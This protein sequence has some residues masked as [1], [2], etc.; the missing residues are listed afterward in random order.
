MAN[1]NRDR[2]D[3]YERGSEYRDF[4]R[5]H[6]D[7]GGSREYRRGEQGREYGGEE[8]HPDYSHQPTEYAR[9]RAESERGGLTQQYNYPGGSYATQRGGAGSQGYV[10]REQIARYGNHFQPGGQTPYYGQESGGGERFGEG[11]RSAE[12]GYSGGSGY[13]QGERSGG[14]QSYEANQGY[15]PAVGVGQGYSGPAGYGSQRSGEGNDNYGGIE[16]YRGQG[17]GQQY[18]LAGRAEGQYLGRSGY[19]EEHPPGMAP[20]GAGLRR[21]GYRGRGPRN[22]RRSDERITEEINDR[23]T[24]HDELDAEEIEVNV[25]GGEVILTGTV[26]SRESKRLAEDLAESVAGVMQVQN[27]LRVSRRDDRE[28]H[29]EGR[30]KSSQSESQRSSRGSKA[31]TS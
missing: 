21:G 31:S 13:S 5:Q 12:R 18:G 10:E 6:E 22:Y 1:Y 24:D 14:N 2:G 30:G 28:R 7:Q 19:A 15:G 29:S 4:G 9:R 20:R 23:L 16:G 25:T 3:D 11:Q 17:Y 8:R 26:D 27:Q